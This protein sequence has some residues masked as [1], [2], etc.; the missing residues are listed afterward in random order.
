MILRSTATS[1][2]GRLARIVRIEKGLEDRVAFEVVMTRGEGNPYYEINPSGRV[3]S[4]TLDDGTCLEDSALV[5]WYLDHIDGAPT[6]HPAAGMEGLEHRRVEAVARSMLDGI[7]LWSR[8]FLYREK[9]IRSQTLI[10][11][12]LARALR[13]ADVFERDVLTP[14]MT[15]PLNMA[16]IAL[17]CI[18]HGRPNNS[19]RGFTWQEGR[20]N[21]TAW[22][23]RIGEIPSIAETV[24]PP[25]TK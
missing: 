15:G 10:N 6:L 3:P 14:V 11:H 9:E 16:Q 13:L 5:C 7:S 1:P 23:E 8:E 25:R 19:P 2:Y 18:L 12:E 20:P 4:L 21:L 24:P 22:V 17:A